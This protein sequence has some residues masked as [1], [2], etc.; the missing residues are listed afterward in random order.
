MGL[1][2]SSSERFCQTKSP[3]DQQGTELLPGEK[4]G[5]IRLENRLSAIPLLQQRTHLYFSVSFMFE[6]RTFQAGLCAGFTGSAVWVWP[7]SLDRRQQL[8]LMV[9]MI[10]TMGISKVWLGT[11]L[12]FLSWTYFFPAVLA[13][14]NL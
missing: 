9:P 11:H 2:T 7:P 5:E 13:Q 1:P 14:V 8:L 10:N 3:K 4:W 12:E 6:K